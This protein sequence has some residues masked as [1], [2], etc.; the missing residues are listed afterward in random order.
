MGPWDMAA[1]A[2]LV[3]EAGGTITLANGSP[4]ILPTRNF[5]AA[6]NASTLQEFRQLLAE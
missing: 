5:A 1:G 6:A 2:I 3:E 4:F